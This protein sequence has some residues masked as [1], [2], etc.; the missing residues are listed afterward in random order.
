VILC[1]QWDVLH[2]QLEI[3]IASMT[4][5]R[6]HM[7]PHTGHLDRMKHKNVYLIKFMSATTQ[8]R[9]IN[10][11]LSEDTGQLF[12][13]YATLYSNIQEELIFQNPR[14]TCSA[15]LHM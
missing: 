12:D 2:I 3:R 11:D 15:V 6:I 4:V 14:P 10:P 13:W 8:Y 1:L 5:S 7:A 9:L